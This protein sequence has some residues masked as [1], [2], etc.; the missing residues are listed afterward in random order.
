MSCI[1][2]RHVERIGNILDYWHMF[3]SCGAGCVLGLEALLADRSKQARLPQHEPPQP[4]SH[5]AG[6]C[7][8]IVSLS[9]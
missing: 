7:K 3:F 6:I 4:C 5:K 2:D 9:F 1:A 8:F